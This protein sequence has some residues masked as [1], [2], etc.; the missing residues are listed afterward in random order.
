MIR[1]QAVAGAVLSVLGAAIAI[2]AVSYA[3]WTRRVSNMPWRELG[4]RF[5]RPLWVGLVPFSAGGA[6]RAQSVLEAATW[7]GVGCYATARAWRRARTS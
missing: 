4:P 5:A 7:V 1:W 6:L 3:H 2:S